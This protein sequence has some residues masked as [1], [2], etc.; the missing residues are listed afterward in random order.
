MIIIG[1]WFALP[2]ALDTEIFPLF[3]VVSSSMCIS[4][5]KCGHLSHTLEHTF[6]RTLHVGDLIIIQGVDAENLRVDYPNSDIIVFR[7]PQMAVNDPH[8]NIVHR[9][10]DTVEVDGIVYFYT[11]GDGNNY[12]NIWPQEPTRIDSWHSTSEDSRS[13]YDG[14]ISEDY[15]YGKVVMRIP[16]LGA[17]A[18]QSQKN[19]SI[20]VILGIII[21]LLVIFEFILPIVKKRKNKN[22]KAITVTA[23]E[24]SVCDASVE[25]LR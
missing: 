9:I 22:I 4:T 8:A 24:Q 7:N 16:W 21:V 1:F 17:I 10:T 13:T 19:S 6:E 2:K 14:A 3:V 23:E 11:K 25:E 5:E 15:V 20:P 18:M 12:P